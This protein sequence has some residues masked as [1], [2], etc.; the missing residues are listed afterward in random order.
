MPNRRYTQRP[1]IGNEKSALR[2]ESDH[3]RSGIDRRRNRRLSGPIR[4]VLHDPLSGSFSDRITP[5]RLPKVRSS[6]FP[7]RTLS[8]SPLSGHRG[9]QDAFG[10]AASHEI[11]SCWQL[12]TVCSSPCHPGCAVRECR[13]GKLFVATINPVRALRYSCSPEGAQ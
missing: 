10:C 6:H 3:L 2:V 13:L 12:R 1:P 8:P 11:C 9:H 5:S 4:E 7:F